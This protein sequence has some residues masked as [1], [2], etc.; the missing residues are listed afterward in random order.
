MIKNPYKAKFLV[1]VALSRFDATAEPTLEG[2]A[3]TD[4]LG[5][6]VDDQGQAINVMDG[7]PNRY[8]TVTTDPGSDDWRID[9]ELN[10]RETFDFALLD[11]INLLQCYQAALSGSIAVISHTSD[12]VGSGAAVTVSKRLSGFLSKG[13]PHLNFK[14]DDYVEK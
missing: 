10:K 12:V 5:G 7:Y 2:L 11:R 3:G 14:D 13:R 4:Y 6:T 9:L 1:P 8:L